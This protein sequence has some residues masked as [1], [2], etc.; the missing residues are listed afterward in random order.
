DA[1]KKFRAKVN[2]ITARS[3]YSNATVAKMFALESYLRGWGNYYRFA[4]N[5]SRVFAK[6]DHLVFWQMAH[7]LGAKHKL[8]I[9]KV[10]RQYYK[11]VEGVMTFAIGEVALW[12]LCRLKFE[13]LY[14][15]T[16]LNPYAEPETP[17]QREELPGSEHVWQG[18]ETR[19]G[20][21]DLRP[22]VHARDSWRCQRCG[23]Q[24]N[25]DTV[26]LDHVK[27][28]KRF[29]RP[30]DAS[31][32]DNLQTLC[33]PCHTQKSIEEID[34]QM[35]CRMQRK[36]HVR[37]GGGSE[38]NVPFRVIEWVTRLAPILHRKSSRWPR[39]QW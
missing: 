30:E 12:R 28:V 2:A 16:F 21:E 1:V 6:L 38:G 10:M 22:L 32:L 11:R 4:Y 8:Q 14:Q 26:C 23:T 20:I 35:K 39:Q 13:H 33:I 9:A 7:W 15:K 36:L 29:S 5:A 24:V 34:E 37:F 19:P 17:L 3:T 18:N 25:R 31:V 27:P